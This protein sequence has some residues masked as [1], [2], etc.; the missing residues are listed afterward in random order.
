MEADGQE[1]LG[2]SW[3]GLT[4]KVHLLSDDRAR[5]LTWQ[6][7]PGQRGDGPMFITLLDSLRV[8]RREPGRPRR[9]PD[10]VH[11]DKAN[12]SRDNRAHLG[13]QG[14]RATIAHPDDQR[15]SRKRKR[16]ASGR[17][18]NFDKTRP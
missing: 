6:T 11:G 2:R 7:T 1:V 12:S 15:A 4:S 14:I 17:P 9:R 16:R 5:P 10:R 3:G 18:P 8:Q 13:R